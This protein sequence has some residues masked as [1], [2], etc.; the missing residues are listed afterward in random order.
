MVDDRLNFNVHVDYACEKAATAVNTLARIIPSVGGPR[1]SKRRFLA[2]VATSILS[3]SLGCGAKNEEKPWEA[4]Q[5]V[6]AHGY[7]SREC[8]QNNPV[9][10]EDVECYRRRNARNTRAAARTNS[11][12]KWQQEWDNAANG[13]KQREVNFQLTQ[14]LS[15]HGCFRKYLFRF[16]HVPS[17]LRPEYV[18]VEETPAHV[19]FDCPRIAEIR[20]GIRGVTVANIVEEMF[21]NEDT[22]NVV[23]RKVTGILCALQRKWREGQRAPDSDPVRDDPPPGT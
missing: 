16:G 22:W 2:N 9:G 14:F 18:N 7:E 21:R 6:P 13:R 12:A 4:E 23:D 15:G 10:E 11:L 3:A 1:S 17:P 8:L 5:C 19:V 20:R